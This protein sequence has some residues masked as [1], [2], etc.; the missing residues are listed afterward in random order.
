MKVKQLLVKKILEKADLYEWSLQ[1]FGMLRMYLEPEIR[2]HI[3]DSRYQIENV[4]IIHTHPWHFTSTVI[5]GC[6]RNVEYEDNENLWNFEFSNPHELYTQLILTGENAHGVQPI[7]TCR[8][9]VKS[10]RVFYP[11]QSYRQFMTIPHQTFFEDGTVTVIERSDR[12][13]QNHA[14]TYWDR[15]LGKNGW[16][17]AAPRKATKDE[18]IDI[19]Q[20]ALHRWFQ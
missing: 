1:G 9:A 13:E 3:W 11:G 18:I 17:S 7:E 16:V 19:T 15:S 8:L 10:E 6:V 14:Y 20:N 12:T 2:L 5:A 4:S